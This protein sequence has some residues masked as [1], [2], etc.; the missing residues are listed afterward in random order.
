L[1]TWRHNVAPNSARK[2]RQNKLSIYYW[3][4]YNCS[5]VASK[6][7]L[8]HFHWWWICIKRLIFRCFFF[9]KYDI[10]FYSTWKFF[11]SSGFSIFHWNSYLTL[12][13]QI[14]R[15]CTGIHARI[16]KKCH[17]SVIWVHKDNFDIF[18][19]N[20]L[21]YPFITEMQLIR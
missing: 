21:E 18:V 5:C 8:Y 15:I 13:T 7:I 11:P 10:H 14:C 3:S 2:Y 4:L 9:V 16:I 19:I 17:F 20:L 6:R 1:F 12:Y